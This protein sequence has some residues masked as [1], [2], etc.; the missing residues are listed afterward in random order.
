[1]YGCI[2]LGHYTTTPGLTAAGIREVQWNSNRKGKRMAELLG[3]RSAFLCWFA[4]EYERLGGSWA[5]GM[6]EVTHY[7]FARLR[8]RIRK[9]RKQKRRIL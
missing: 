3:M 5:N 4:V 1:M 7:P 6:R 2:V 8:R 9:A